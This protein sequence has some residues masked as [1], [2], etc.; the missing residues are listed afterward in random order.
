MS[1]SARA[2]EARQQLD[3]FI[4]LP[5]D[6]PTH[7]QQEL[8]ERPFF[9]LSKSKRTAP[10]DYAVR[11]G[12]TEITVRV[13]APDE[14][15]IAT[16]WDADILIWAASQLREAKAKGLA[17]S[18]TFRVHPY[19]LLKAIDRPT[20]GVD[21][22]RLVEALKRLAATFITTNI[23]AGG[24]KKLSGFHWVERW[25][26]PVDEQGRSLPLE[27]TIADWLY[28]GILEDRLALTIDR[29]YFRLTGGVERWLYRVVR[30]HGGHQA[31]GWAFT[32]RQLHYKSGSLAE[33]KEFTRLLRGVV[34]RQRLPGYWLE[35]RR[36]A[37]GEEVL[38]FVE[39]CQLSPD[40][41]GYAAKRL[42][43][44]HV[45][46]LVRPAADPPGG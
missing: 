43:R 16:I 3:L 18:R 13:V 6:I 26:A 35:T 32:F 42:P 7:D 34:E 8:M 39:R 22:Q 31:A 21:Y 23:R 17:T 15:G 19:E 14:I 11:N 25:E 28:D 10:I 9:S 12:A 2:A 46:R 45:G 36:N 37:D 38:C 20:G 27:F 33:L 24:R 1:R 29:D 5:G 30:K 44:L 4:A 41:P 40:H